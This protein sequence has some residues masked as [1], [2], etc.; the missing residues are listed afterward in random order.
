MQLPGTIGKVEKDWVNYAQVW[1][2]EF[3]NLEF[4]DIRDDFL[5]AFVI[6]LSIS[7]LLEL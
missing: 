7:T 3:T 5:K 2:L 4:T 1:H 6:C